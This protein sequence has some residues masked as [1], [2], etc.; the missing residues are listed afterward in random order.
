MAGPAW[1]RPRL[2][3]LAARMAALL[4]VALLPLGLIA[5]HQTRGLQQ[6]S[7]ETASLTLLALTAAGSAGL[8]E[9]V[10]RGL[11]VA[12]S[13][14]A[15]SDLLD[16][17]RTCRERLSRLVTPDGP[18]AFAGLL[19]EAGGLVTCST[20]P[21]PF[22]MARPAD[23]GP[24]MAEPRPRLRAAQ[25][26][27]VSGEDVLIVL[28]PVTPPVGFRGYVALSVR[29]DALEAAAPAPDLPRPAAL[30]A[31][32]RD[33]VV[34]AA[35]APGGASQVPPEELAALLPAGRALADERAGAPRVFEATD[36]AGRERLY[37]VVP[38]VPEVAYAM[39]VW[40]PADAGPRDEAP[41]L[42][43]VV[44]WAASLLVAFY[45]MHRLVVSH[46][47]TL[48]ARMR[49]FAQ[50]R[51][52]GPPLQGAAPE[53]REIDESFRAAARSIVE[54]E[55]RM[56]AAFRERGV[57]LREVHHRVKNN[58]QLISSIISMQVRRTGDAPTRAL[59]RRLQDRVLTL[60]GIYRVLYTGADMGAVN[61]AE[62]LGAIIDR[63]L[64]DARPRAA[65]EVALDDLVLDPDKVVPLAFLVA[66]ALSNA[67][68]RLGGPEP[69]L[70]VTLRREGEAARLDLVNTT[71]PGAQA[72]QG[73]GA[74]LIRAFAAQMGGAVEEAAEDG[75][76]R[77]AVTFP[78]DPPA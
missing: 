53:L 24:M 7:E 1:R 9:G 43:P 8:R 35:E 67:V 73:L 62:V 16:D 54:D 78:L 75:L 11:G 56:E 27:R 55:A 51:G 39:G 50:D 76:H 60:A 47:S 77:L 33:G 30:L 3:G 21:A 68:A 46:V 45:G 31:F 71:G 20:A 26:G 42:F 10:E 58:L 28:S 6:Q 25:E 36:A 41:L 40:S 52:I 4:S 49:R 37:T 65:V 12:E 14:G 18:Y 63:E 2:D 38:L 19:P 32:D 59:L 5:L 69:R 15:V 17:P 74:H 44:M 22:A 64:Q 66:E 13:L 61:A 29:R 70:Q 48:G 23:M 34:L 57:L 72:R